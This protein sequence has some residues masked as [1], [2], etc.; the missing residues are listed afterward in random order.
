ML[1]LLLGFVFLP[2]VRPIIYNIGAVFD[3]SDLQD[4]SAFLKAIKKVN[5]RLADSPVRFHAIIETI[6]KDDL[7][8]ANWA[9]EITVPMSYY[10]ANQYCREFSS[11]LYSPFEDSD[12]L[13][14]MPDGLNGWVDAKLLRDPYGNF[15]IIDGRNRVITDK[16]RKHWAE[17]GDDFDRRLREDFTDRSTKYYCFYIE[18]GTNTFFITLCTDRTLSFGQ[19]HPMVSVC[20]ENTSFY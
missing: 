17:E 6:D 3:K 12:N 10:E 4:A 7:I 15:Q 8:E 13:S 20:L 5:D 18:G 14:I 11:H 19:H 1:P 9:N 2:F 16:M